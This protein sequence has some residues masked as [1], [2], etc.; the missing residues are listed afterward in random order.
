[1]AKEVISREAAE[2]EWK[3]F[4]DDKDA[5]SLMPNELPKGASK[6]E[7]DENNGKQIAFEKVVKAI[8]RGLVI[9]EDG[10][11]TQNLK[12]PITGEG[13]TIV[14]DKLVYNNRWTAKDREEAFKGIDSKKA[15]DNFLVSRRMCSKITGVSP[16]ILTKIDGDDQKV[17]DNIVSVFFM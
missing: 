12:Y 4:L 8:M 10:I 15:D 11:I 14:V 16:I 7:I 1:M 6:E 9:I 5:T 3:A 17:T 2:K 13:G